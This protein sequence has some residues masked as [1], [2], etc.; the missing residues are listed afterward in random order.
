MTHVEVSS[1][2]LASTAISLSF[3]RVAFSDLTCRPSNPTAFFGNTPLFLPAI[4]P[5]LH[6]ET[7]VASNGVMGV[8][9]TNDVSEG[10]GEPPPRSKEA[11][12]A[13]S[14]THIVFGN[15]PFYC[16]NILLGAKL[17][18]TLLPRACIH[19]VPTLS[20]QSYPTIE[21]WR[22]RSLDVAHTEGGPMLLPRT[23]P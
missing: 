16:A 14:A 8:C 18:S 1:W 23:S 6:A 17:G 22:V 11:P 13:N 19:T 15:W 7:P 3:A 12:A 2:R 9:C 5:F 10:R 20:V 4:S 21:R